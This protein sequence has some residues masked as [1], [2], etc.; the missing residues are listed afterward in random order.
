MPNQIPN[1]VEIAEQLQQNKL[2]MKA[3]DM[4]TTSTIAKKPISVQ[5]T[6]EYVRNLQ[7]ELKDTRKELREASKYLSYAEV[8]LVVERA[9]RN[10]GKR[11]S[12]P[13]HFATKTAFLT[14]LSNC[15]YEAL[16]ESEPEDRLAE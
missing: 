1:W 6:A 4:F 16:S 2:A 12:M 15:L 11:T 8:R 7:Q 10:T 9:F 3:A 14:A 13:R 5:T